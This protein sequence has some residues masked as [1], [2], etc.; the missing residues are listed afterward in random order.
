MNNIK[1]NIMRGK[2]Q[3][4]FFLY[5]AVFFFLCQMHFSLFSLL[6]FFAALT[7]ALNIKRSLLSQKRTSR[8]K[9]SVVSFVD[10]CNFRRCARFI[11]RKIMWNR[12]VN[13]ENGNV[14]TFR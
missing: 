4:F 9:I 6:S 13:K 8:M 3:H 5:A 2:L 11:V 14:F 12:G 1:Y 10:G 7:T